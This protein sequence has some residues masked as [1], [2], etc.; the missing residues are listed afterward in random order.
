CGGVYTEPQGIVQSPLY[1]NAYPK[2][3][4][5]IYVVQA[6]PGKAIDFQF[7]SFDIEG[8]VGCIFD[9]IEFRDGH[10][11]NSPLIERYC[12]PPERIP[13]PVISTHNYLYAKFVTDGSVQNHGF[14]ANYS[15]IDV[16][17]GGIFTERI[18]VIHSPL[19]PDVYPN[20]ARCTYIVAGAVG[21]IV[22]LTFTSFHLEEHVRCNFDYLEV[23][24][25][26]TLPN[27]GGLVGRYCGR[28]NPPVLTSTENVMTLIF[29]SDHSIG[30]Q[31]FSAAYIIL[32]DTAECGGTYYTQLGVIATPNYPDGYPHNLDC[33]WIISAPS[34]RQIN[35]NVS[36]FTLEMH[37]E[38]QY[39]YLEIRNGGYANSPLIGKYCGN[40]LEGQVIPSHGNKLWMRLVTDRSF[41]ARGFRVFW[42]SSSTGCGGETGGAEG[43]IISP[44]Y[45]SPYDHRARCEWII[46]VNSGSRVRLTFVDFDVDSH[47]ACRRDFVSIREGGTRRGRRVGTYCGNNAP[48]PIVT[49]GNEVHVVF[50]SDGFNN[51]R[52]F[53]LRYRIVCDNVIETGH[54][55]HGVIESP[56]FPNP[57]PHNRN[58]T[59]TLRAPRGSVLLLTF[60]HFSI[61]DHHSGNCSYDFLQVLESGTSGGT[62][63][64][65]SSLGKFCGTS[66]I[67]QPIQST[68]D[69]VYVV[70]Q[71]DYSV[72]YNGF[73][74]EWMVLG[75]GGLF[76]KPQGNFRSP[77][78]PNPYPHE[79]DCDWRIVVDPGSAVRLTI[80]DFDIE[81]H[82]GFDNLTIYGGP[83]PTS[84]VLTTLCE[85]EERG[86]VVTSQGNQMLVSLR[87][88]VSVSGRGFNASWIT[89]HSNCGGLFTTPTG[90]I[91]SP[92]YPQNYDHSDD[93]GYLIRVDANH[94][95]EL[96]F[97][98]FDVEPHN[99]CSYD[100]VALFDGPDENSPELMRHCGASLP[101]P[102]VFRSTGNEMF[103]RLKADGFA[104]ARG[105][106]ANYS[107][108]CGARIVTEDGGVIT[109][110]HYPHL[111][112]WKSFNCSWIVQ[113]A[114]PDERI[115]ITVG[116][117]DLHSTG[118][119]NCSEAYLSILEGEGPDATEIGRFCG[120]A[121]PPA[122]FSRGA[123]VVVRM[124]VVLQ[125]RNPLRGAG[126]S[127]GYSI[128]TG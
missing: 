25:N 10:D 97:V 42:D 105:F 45:P 55:R 13:L 43:S 50:R 114:R 20:R 46:R 93:C 90:N 51:G 104:A 79:V 17:C 115:A 32:N 111:L 16:G 47:P 110:P 106:M 63:G 86:K 124:V 116:D 98:D 56:N 77:N 5:C 96:Q 68:K 26:T 30:G 85:K 76:R 40:Q 89:Q 41:S 54:L 33:T 70:F 49:D 65:N 58:C 92:N 11:E 101:S 4:E 100:Y 81:G 57:Y 118:D 6:P 19:H 8:S 59:W 72:A 99:N 127:L 123:V 87:S 84:P 29:R 7:N 67:P 95:V 37:Q 35:L 74:L 128:A 83:E 117:L 107:R 120:S 75:C 112:P 21:T 23:Y 121:V 73:R 53:N 2:D 125:S 12:G 15:F 14:M 82:C 60:S 64:G 62:S 28:V 109:S 48:D 108:V 80:H 122:V 18:G 119:H 24:D 9:Y 34:G 102:A 44:N 103:L 31:G 22:R 113:A 39:D 71:S 66:L 52:G 36:D 126:F 1:P 27:T 94:A 88:D 91:L 3:R 69:T 38:C 61:E 78:Y